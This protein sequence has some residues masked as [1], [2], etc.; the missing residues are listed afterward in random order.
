MA[1]YV[2]RSLLVYVCRTV[3]GIYVINLLFFDELAHT[4]RGRLHAPYLSQVPNS[5]ADIHQQC[6]VQL[7]SISFISYYLHKPTVAVFDA[8]FFIA[9]LIT[10]AATPPDKPYQCILTDCFNNC[11]FSKLI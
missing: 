9:D 2:V 10:Y 5:A 4:S 3:Q 6:S 7:I 11:N 8:M 1:A